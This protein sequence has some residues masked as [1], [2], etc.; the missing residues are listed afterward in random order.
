MAARD[1]IPRL[2]VEGED[3]QH[4]ILQLICRHGISL[5]KQSG[6][7]ILEPLGSDGKVLDFIAPG[8]KRSIQRSV[9]FVLDIDNA[10]ADRWR[11]VSARLAE[12]KIS[13]PSAMPSDGFV[14]VAPET[15][16]Q[17]GIW[18]MPDCKAPSGKLEDLLRTLVPNDDP[19]VEFAEESTREASVRGAVFGQRD[20][21]KAIIHCWL[22]WQASPGQ[23]YG[24]AIRMKY[25]RHDN[26]VATK[27]V[28]WF[29]RTFGI[30][31]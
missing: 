3:D 17:V 9:G 22:A 20:R 12:L 10:L 19:L 6:P 30:S 1:E 5:D 23:S 14:G 2:Y 29:C 8:V 31:R 16:T 27:F 21:I 4:S 28:E 13:C 15:K 24:H 7:V 25:F 18:L 11:A 26:E